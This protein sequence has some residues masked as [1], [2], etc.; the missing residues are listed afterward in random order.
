MSAMA[1]GPAQIPL[2]LRLTVR[3]DAPPPTLT[4]KVAVFVPVLVGLNMM[5]ILHVPPTG[6]DAPHVV[7]CEN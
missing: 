5:L 6:T 2:P 4:I 1:R 7:D 3:S